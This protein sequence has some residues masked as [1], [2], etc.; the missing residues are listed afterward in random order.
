MSKT[1]SILRRGFD[2]REPFMTG[3]HQ[4]INSVGATQHN[5]R[6]STLPAW[7]NDDEKVRQLLLRV[8]PKLLTDDRQRQRARRWNQVIHFY[9]RMGLTH[10]QIADE[11][12][13]PAAAIGST[14]Q[15]IYYAAAGRRSDTGKPLKGKRG[16]PKKN[17][18]VIQTSHGEPEK[19][20]GE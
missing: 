4:L 8:F 11:M 16:R 12:G 5:R 2:N 13:E 20:H 9:F 18:D 3:G 6:V 15:K 19:Q 14:I 10:N 7:A 1:H 17:K